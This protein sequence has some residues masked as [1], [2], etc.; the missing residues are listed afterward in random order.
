MKQRVSERGEV[1]VGEHLDVVAVPVLLE[2][3]RGGLARTPEGQ[4][5]NRRK[6]SVNFAVM[7][8]SPG[9]R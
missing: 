7:L 1:G 8:F 4:G 9:V 3:Q 2:F 5:E 6:P